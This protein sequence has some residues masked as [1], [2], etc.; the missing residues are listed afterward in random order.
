MT[1]NPGKPVFRYRV[2]N[3][4]RRQGRSVIVH[5]KE[6]T[7]D[8]RRVVLIIEIF[9]RVLNISRGVQVIR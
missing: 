4:E 3:F 9:S 1:S 5:I 7:A 6:N 8:G 2:E